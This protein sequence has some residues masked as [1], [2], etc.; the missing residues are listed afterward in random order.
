MPAAASADQWR[1]KSVSQVMPALKELMK[2]DPHVKAI[3]SSG[4]SNDPVLANYETHGFC[5]IAIKPYDFDELNGIVYNAMT[6][7]S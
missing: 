6:R 3:A 1:P 5:D 4:Y 7:Q 2:I